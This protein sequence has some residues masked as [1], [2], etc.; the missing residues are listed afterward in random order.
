MI[1][2]KR[3]GLKM[4]GK[5]IKIKCSF[6]NNIFNTYI[7]K[8]NMSKFH[9]CSKKCYWNHKKELCLGK[10]NNQFGKIGVLSPNYKAGGKK[11]YC[12]DCNKIISWKATYCQKHA[13]IG[14]RNPNFEKD[15]SME[16]SPAWQG[17]KSF[18]EYTVK[19]TKELKEKI[20]NRDNYKCRICNSSQIQN[21]RLDVHHIDYNKQN[22][23]EDNL[24]T[25]CKKHH[26]KTNFNRIYWT[27]YFR[28]LL[29]CKIIN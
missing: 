13:Y 3:N 26:M 12:K 19:F 15:L 7:C 9:Y 23:N 5:Q 27:N 11:Y 10:N 6:C 21:S 29:K 25:L 20:R 18:E 14:N 1:K 17:G 22:C 28:R 16:K 4:R 2:I 24:I 8:L